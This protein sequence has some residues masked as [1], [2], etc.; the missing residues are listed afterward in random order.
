MATARETV[1]HV[2]Y[3]LKRDVWM[4]HLP[5]PVPAGT[6]VTGVKHVREQGG[7][8][9]VEGWSRIDGKLTLV[10]ACEHDLEPFIGTRGLSLVGAIREHILFVMRLAEGNVSLAAHMLQIPRR[11]LQRKLVKLDL[12]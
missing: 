3:A 1:K 12:R 8:N 6:I 4:I 2:I 11:T 7:I 5:K 9:I 10:V